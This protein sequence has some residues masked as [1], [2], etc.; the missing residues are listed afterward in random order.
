[1]VTFPDG[2][3]V[4]R[5]SWLVGSTFFLQAL[6]YQL[7]GAWNLENWPPPL[8]VLEIILA[9]GSPLAIQIYRYVRLSNP[10]QR[11][12]TRWVIF[13][14]VCFVLLFVLQTLAEA[15]FPSLNAPNSLYP[16]V[17]ASLIPSISILFIPI[18]V[19]MAILRSQLW[20]IDVIIRRTL[21]YTILTLILALIYVGLIFTLGAL[22]RSL[23]GVY[24]LLRQALSSGRLGQKRWG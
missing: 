11:Q 1:M 14:L 10:A 5:W 7:P 8:F 15:I 3:L 21:V 9:F 20:D 19:S 22:L 16:L 12:Q 6:L 13:A 18:G 23:F 4:P 24:A 17:S 2:R